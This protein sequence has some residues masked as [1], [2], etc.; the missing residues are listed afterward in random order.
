MGNF[1]GLPDGRFLLLNGISTGTAG[2]GNTSWAVGQ[3]FGDNP[4]YEPAY[5]DPLLPSGQRFY[6]TNMGNSTVPRLYH[7]SAT[8]LP[9]GSVFSSGSNPNAD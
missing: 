3:S 2:Y 1:I 7:S 6:R 5:Y 4:I 9:D 8:L